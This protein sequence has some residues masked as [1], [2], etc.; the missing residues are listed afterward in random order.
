VENHVKK[1]LPVLEVSINPVTDVLIV[2]YDKEKVS[3]DQ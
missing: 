1:R 2:K 3:A